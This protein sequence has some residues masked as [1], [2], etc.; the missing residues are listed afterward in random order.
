[1]DVSTA[2]P[3]A[4]SGVSDA[5]LAALALEWVDALTL[6]EKVAYLCADHPS[7]PR[8]GLKAHRLEAEGA[9]GLVIRAGQSFMN[10]NANTTVFPEPFGLSMTWDRELLRR[11]GEVVSDEARALYSD[12]LTTLVLFSPTIDLARDPRWGRNEEAYGED[13]YLAGQLGLSY[14]KGLQGDQY[15]YLKAAATTKHFYANNYEFERDWDNSIVPEHLRRDYYLRP[16]EYAFAEGRAAAAMAGYNAVNGVIGM[17]N[18][19][20]NTILRQEW[21]ADG[22]FV[23]DGKAFEILPEFYGETGFAGATDV[24]SIHDFE[25]LHAEAKLPIYARYAKAALDAGLDCFLAYDNQVV[26]DAVKHGLDTG[27]IVEADIDRA[28]FNQ[29]KIM[30]RLGIVPGFG[31]NPYSETP[32]KLLTKEA[33]GLARRAAIESVVLLKNDGLLPLEPGTPQNIAVIGQLGDQNVRDWYSGSPPYQVSPR[34][35]IAAAFPGS[36]VVFDDGCDVIAF[37]V[38]DGDS[39]ERWLTVDDDGATHLNGKAADRA[40]FR[41]LD[42]GYGVAFQD[43]MTNKYLTTTESGELRA[44][45]DQVW[46]WF[47]RELFFPGKPNVYSRTDFPPILD[48]IAG[49]GLTTDADLDGQQ[50]SPEVAFGVNAQPPGAS[51]PGKNQY[52]KTY[53]PGAV[54]K[55]NRTLAKLTIKVIDNGLERAA[56]LAKAADV[57]VV[58]VGNHPLVGAREC[59]D[60]LST[61]F[62]AR[63]SALLD[64]VSGTNPDTVLC[65]VAGYQY[66]I[67]QAESQAKAVLFTSHGMQ[68]LGTAI[69]ETLSGTNNPS[70]KLSQ[71]WYADDHQFASMSDYDIAASGTTYLYA[72][73][74]PLHPFGFGLS[75]TTF[76][77]GD[78]S[79]TPNVAGVVV[80]FNL[81]NTGAGAGTEVAQVYLLSDKPERPSVALVGFDRIALEPGETKQV[82]I[83]VRRRE[84]SFWD[85]AAAEFRPDAGPLTLAVGASSTDL[86]LKAKATL[87]MP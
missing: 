27:L 77:Y 65:L 18:P 46:G 36:E 56:K 84:L 21:G 33:C 48:G 49:V 39:V 47:N 72:Q 67:G 43:M 83:E 79:I 63:W 28:I 34:Q 76:E 2:A 64:T 16:F 17:L 38:T 35:G 60:R 80:T 13:P 87:E 9:H 52:L 59:I 71:T 42:W 37:A 66:A 61:A 25:S 3:A 75:Y 54:D 1:M 41:V 14:I 30:L 12:T 53:Q 5:A 74:S 20:F 69:G 68:E 55:L 40:T 70:G 58:V 51:R 86:R 26:I 24:A 10:V 7:I 15:P 22:Y 23:S 8:L 62:P 29:F 45:A 6:G 44:D 4:V 50:L 19:E 85:A 73:S 32:H 78:L 82:T 81:T 57:A 11:V 31:D